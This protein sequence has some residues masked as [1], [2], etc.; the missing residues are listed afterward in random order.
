[1]EQ[2]YFGIGT[3]AAAS[4][5]TAETIRRWEARGAISL[6]RTWTGRRVFSQADIAK[7]RQLAGRGGASTSEATLESDE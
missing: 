1:M 3:A 6:G 4:G 5:V 2:Q 7:L